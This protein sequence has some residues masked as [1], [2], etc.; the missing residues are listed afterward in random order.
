MTATLPRITNSQ[1]AHNMKQ[2]LWILSAGMLLTSCGPE[3]VSRPLET[4][5]MPAEWEPHDAVWLGWESDTTS[6]FEPSVVKMIH[7]LQPHVPVKIAFS[8]D[9][10]RQVASARL[11]E[12]GVDTQ[13]IKMYVMPGERYWI[14]DHGAAFLVNGKGELGVA[15][16]DW[17]FYGMPAYMELY[18]EGNQDSIQ[19]FLGKMMPGMV[20]TG[21]VD[22]LMAVA[23]GAAI[24]KTSV[25][26][27]GGAIEVNGKG[28]LILCEATVFQRN[29][30]MSK[31]ALES[32]FKRAL[33]VSK[34][35]WMKQGLADDPHFFYRRIAG[36]YVGG[37]TGG[38]TDEFVRFA[39]PN[40][41]L[42]AWVDEDE[43]DLNP[44]NQMNYERMSENYEILKNATDQ[45]GNPFTIV[46]VPLPDLITE[47][48]VAK[49]EI[50]KDLFTLDLPSEYFVPSEGVKPG[51][52]L[53][54]VPAAS[55]MNYLVTNGV[56]LLPSYTAMG[57]SAEKEEAIR[58]IFEAQFPGRELV[59]IDAMMQNWQGGGIHC[60]TQQQ[61][62]RKAE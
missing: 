13:G 35:I 23:E 41:I 17:D 3:K 38:H 22:S 24:L 55:Y 32:E 51:D 43:K 18:Y 46:K 62:K 16:F 19:G 59:F 48:V 1:P 45:D 60:S 52:T 49:K 7:A 27:E 14:R 6:R 56:V 12:M 39:N 8:S 47:R 5:Y 54:R 50:E 9:S 25:V 4:F 53:L 30:G 42:L 11:L 15:D 44:I 10:L 58:S 40:T 26:H 21:R 57:S 28:T 37:G 33:G 36:D 29:P 20:K 31:D 34:I 2:L 61:P